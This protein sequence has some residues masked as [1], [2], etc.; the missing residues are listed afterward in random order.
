M[1]SA[2][3]TAEQ[4][5]AK[6]MAK[7]AARLAEKPVLNK[8]KDGAKAAPAAEIKKVAPARAEPKPEPKW[9]W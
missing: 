3:N 9:T 4:T 2:P 8:A 5:A 1:K 7:I 6:I